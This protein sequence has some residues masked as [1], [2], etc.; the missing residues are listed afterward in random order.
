MNKIFCVYNISMVRYYVVFKGQVQGVG[1][2]FTLYN[3]ARQNGLTGW[4]R[5]RFDGAVEAQIQGE[6]SKIMEV[7]DLLR[8]SSRFIDI[9]D[10]SIKEMDIVTGEKKFNIVY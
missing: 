9:E 5:N 1:F 6:V 4:V 3:Y 2:R 8:N 7:I 10:Y